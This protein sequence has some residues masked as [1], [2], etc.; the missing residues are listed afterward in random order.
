M[1]FTESHPGDDGKLSVLPTAAR[2][3]REVPRDEWAAYA[4]IAGSPALLK[5]VMDDLFANEPKLRESAIATGFYQTNSSGACAT[6]RKA[7]PARADRMATNLSSRPF[8]AG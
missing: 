6:P 5:A 3:V 1:S 2:V 7:S 4:P 8:F